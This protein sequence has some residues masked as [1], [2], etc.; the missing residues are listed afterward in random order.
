VISTGKEVRPY[1]TATLAPGQLRNSTGPYLQSALPLLGAEVLSAATVGDDPGVLREAIS[2]A[3]RAGAD[4][5]ITTGAVSAG[6]HDIVKDVLGALGARVVFHKIAVRPGKPVLLAELPGGPAVLGL[7]GNPVA[8][9]VAARFLVTPFLRAAL[10]LPPE[11]LLRA[12]LSAEAKKPEGLRCFYKACVTVGPRGLEAA[13]TKGQASAIV[14]SLLVANGWLVLPEE[15]SRVPAGTEVEIAPLLAPDP[16][17][18][19][20]VP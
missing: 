17:F 10:G 15:G 2:A 14:S 6:K 20:G 13:P 9:V 19:P 5:V 7:P 18:S 12:V 3:A 11:R 1:A 4:L 16:F 8:S